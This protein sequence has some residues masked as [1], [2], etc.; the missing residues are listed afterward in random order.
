MLDNLFSFIYF[1]VFIYLINDLS[2]I[3]K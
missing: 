3:N 1:M 2:L